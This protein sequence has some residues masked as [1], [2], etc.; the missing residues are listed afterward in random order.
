MLNSLFGWCCNGVSWSCECGVL[1]LCGS[2]D[3]SRNT[4]E[5]LEC[6]KTF[7]VRGHGN[8]Q[9]C[10]CA[11]TE[12]KCSNCQSQQLV[13][14][15]V[16]PFIDKRAEFVNAV[17]L[18]CREPAD[19]IIA[20]ELTDLSKTPDKGQQKIYTSGKS[21][22]ASFITKNDPQTR[23][24][25]QF[26]KDKKDQYRQDILEFKNSFL[27]SF[28]EDVKEKAETA[29][30]AATAIAAAAAAAHLAV[31]DPVQ[32]PSLP[33]LPCEPIREVGDVGSQSLSSRPAEPVL[34]LSSPPSSGMIH[35]PISSCLPSSDCLLTFVYVPRC[36]VDVS[37]SG[38]ARNPSHGGPGRRS[39]R[40]QRCYSRDVLWRFSCHQDIQGSRSA[41]SSPRGCAHAKINGLTQY[42]E[43]L[44]LVR[45][46]CL[47]GHAVL[48]TRITA[49]GTVQQHLACTTHFT[50][51]CGLITL[52]MAICY[53]R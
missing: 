9:C 45:G 12:P 14:V 21:F 4:P 1:L 3:M 19:F 30:A 22:L 8:R 47:P 16:R 2:T 26:Y 31:A 7:Q 13:W 51:L 46:A 53:A 34:V 49:P 41:V 32:I 11:A 39:W 33:P 37:P 50:A 17:Q 28:L 48:S 20:Q 43:A 24:K 27:T 38:K 52:I 42:C 18:G 29:A 25:I 35:M 6:G 36:R 10:I 23:S 40:Q 5:A 15:K 44:R